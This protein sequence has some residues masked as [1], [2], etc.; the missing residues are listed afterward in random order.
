MQW[1]LAFL[2]LLKTQDLHAV[3][4]MLIFIEKDANSMEKMFFTSLS[5][6]RDLVRESRQIRYNHSRISHVPKIYFCNDLFGILCMLSLNF[7]S[8]NFH[9]ACNCISI[10][11]CIQVL[12]HDYSMSK[13]NLNIH[14]YSVRHQLW[15][16]PPI[17][18]LLGV[19]KIMLAQTKPHYIPYLFF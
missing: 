6:F 9:L 10:P 7:H 1:P 19:A 14:R 13:H 16:S 18:I 17:N 8:N 12:H 15:S 4:I 5:S 3:T 2:P 11:S